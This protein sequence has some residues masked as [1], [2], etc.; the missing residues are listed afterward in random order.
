M[1]IGTMS[2]YYFEI[3][4][5]CSF[6]LVIVLLLLAGCKSSE[7]G[8]DFIEVEERPNWQQ[9]IQADSLGFY[10]VNKQQVAN[11]DTPPQI[12][13]VQSFRDAVDI[14]KPCLQYLEDNGSKVEEGDE[15]KVRASSKIE[16]LID[17]KGQAGE[18][19]MLKSMGPCDKAMAKSFRN[20]TFHPAMANNK[21]KATLVHFVMDYNLIGKRI[22]KQ[23]VTTW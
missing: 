22:K 6:T 12:K 17:T 7:T 14:T 19:Y 5:L 10:D 16:F 20:A 1:P 18:F 23:S 15:V 21:P 8:I 2:D 3:S 13:E 9:K 11:I 4:K